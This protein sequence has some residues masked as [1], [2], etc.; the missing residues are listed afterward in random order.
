MDKSPRVL[1]IIKLKITAIYNSKWFLK[2]TQTLITLVFVLLC[3]GFS[4]IAC[5]IEVTETLQDVADSTVSDTTSGKVSADEESSEDYYSQLAVDVIWSAVA[6]VG[7][8][9]LFLY[10]QECFK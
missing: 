10:L 1:F 6:T 5:A 3:T 7:F 8:F 2:V 9:G 4:D